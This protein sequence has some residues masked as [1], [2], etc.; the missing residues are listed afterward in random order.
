MGWHG[1]KGDSLVEGLF[2]YQEKNVTPS[3]GLWDKRNGVENSKVYEIKD[4]STSIKKCGILLKYGV[5]TPSKR[6]TLLL[7]LHP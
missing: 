6:R 3:Y 2:L 4:S 1:I 7:L 5:Q